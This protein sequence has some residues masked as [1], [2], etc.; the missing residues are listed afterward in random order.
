MK[1]I[2]ALAAFASL[3]IT[4]LSALSALENRAQARGAD[5]DDGTSYSR[6]GFDQYEA[7]TYSPEEI[8]HGG[9]RWFGTTTKGVAKA[10]ETVFSQAGRPSGYII[11][12][13]ASG[14]F[15]G[16]L[17]Y[18]EGT[19]YMKDGT[20]KKIYW[21]G[22]S[23]GFDLGGNGSRVLV[24]VYN[25][26]RERQ[27]YD[28]FIGIEGSA[29]M[30]GGLGVNFQSNEELKLAPIRTGVGARLGANVGYL[31]YTEYPTLNPF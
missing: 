18:G 29:Y 12:E 22:P 2:L 20:R 6:S 11:G 5:V 23:V 31:K 17:R 8:V 30:V 26:N 15:F 1:R 3:S 25:I 19:L 9:H 24:L 14:A 13:E 28:R 21:Q 16:G 27:I 4:A 7:G 10:V